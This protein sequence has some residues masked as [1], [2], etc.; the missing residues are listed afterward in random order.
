ML[1]STTGKPEGKYQYQ[2]LI[3]E[4]RS[5]EGNGVNEEEGEEE[6]VAL[7][8]QAAPFPPPSSLALGG[9]GLLSLV[10]AQA[11]WVRSLALNWETME[12]QW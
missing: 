4:V 3:S 8:A 5:V 6:G 10:R 12:V 9:L 11:T 7:R 2:Y 1:T